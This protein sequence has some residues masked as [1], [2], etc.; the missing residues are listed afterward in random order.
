MENKKR[1]DQS[2]LENSKLL[3]SE[4]DD[5][6]LNEANLKYQEE[7]QKY[8]NQN[9]KNKTVAQSNNKNTN[10]Y[11]FN[12][13][14]L[15]QE[16]Q[17]NIINSDNISNYTF[18]A[19]QSQ[20]LS[21]SRRF[22]S[23]DPL[24][25]SQNINQAALNFED[26]NILNSSHL[27]LTNSIAIKK[28]CNLITKCQYVAFSNNYGDNSC[29]V[30]VVLHLLFNIRDL[31][32]I[33][34][35]LYE[36]DEMEKQNPKEGNKNKDSQNKETPQD[37]NTDIN[38]NN[39]KEITTTGNEE[40]NNNYSIPE[41]Y[42]LFVE[43]GEILADYEVY[44]NKENTITQVTILDTRKLRTRLEKVSNGLFPL[45]YVADPVELFIF[46]LDNLNINYQ[47]EIHSLAHQL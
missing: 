22:N 24:A 25:N 29:Y 40:Q 17:N 30:N 20:N 45:N 47:R 14:A 12:F 26:S 31:H 7:L 46:I 34:R 9:Y 10:K 13:S 6:N 3:Y 8:E 44:L 19:N 35:D 4:N 36:I 28:E 2:N 1:L 5:K 39:E 33:F 21:A 15:P 16:N 18:G 23:I 43:I 32:N 42:E 11:H 27:D 37:I 41:I 38:T